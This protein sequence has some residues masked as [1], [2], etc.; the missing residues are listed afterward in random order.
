MQLAYFNYGNIVENG[1]LRRKMLRKF[2][3][4]VEEA[5]DEGKFIKKGK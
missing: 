4:R 5:L 3:K 1:S 2:Q